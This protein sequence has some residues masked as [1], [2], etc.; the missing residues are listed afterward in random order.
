MELKEAQMILDRQRNYFNTGNTLPLQSRINALKALRKAIEAYEDRIVE[1]LKKDLGKSKSESY[2]CE[3]G[4][5]KS[6]ISYMLKHIRK[7]TK[8]KEYVLLLLNMY[9][10]VMKNHVLMEMY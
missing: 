9:Q 5:V 8:E 4:L 3:I 10:E 1:A 7:L 6:E 2:M